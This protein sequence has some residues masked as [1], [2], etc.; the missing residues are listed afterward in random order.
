MRLTRQILERWQVVVYA[1]A[2]AVGTGVGFGLPR[3]GGALAQGLWRLLG[4]LLF[5]T[6]L[7]GA[8]DRCTK[9]ACTIMVQV[10]AVTKK[11]K[12]RAAS[13]RT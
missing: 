3:F 11:A 5:V 10:S 7:Q 9:G 4:V 6:F 13:R 2:I 12:L 8:L 1:V